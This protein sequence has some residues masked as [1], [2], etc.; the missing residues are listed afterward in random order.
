MHLYKKNNLEIEQHLSEIKLP[1]FG[2]QNFVKF[3]AFNQNINLLVFSLNE[4]LRAVLPCPSGRWR[5]RDLCIS[6]YELDP[7]NSLSPK[8][9]CF[10]LTT[11]YDPAS[12]VLSTLEMFP[13]DPQF[14]S[15]AGVRALKQDVP[16]C[17]P[18]CSGGEY[19]KSGV[20]RRKHVKQYF[21]VPMDVAETRVALLN[22]ELHNK[23]SFT[24]ARQ[25]EE[26]CSEHLYPFKCLFEY[27]LLKR[28]FFTQLAPRILP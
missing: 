17:I 5:Q 23:E 1:T 14:A 11:H 8:G 13:E 26:F 10:K 15:F 18:N 27:Q 12:F 9:P 16:V 24:S 19:V 2:R 25:M 7:A 28:E 3:H 4:H 21:G 6:F 22:I 20:K